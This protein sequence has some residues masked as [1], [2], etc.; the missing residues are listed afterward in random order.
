MSYR[1]Q[2]NILGHPQGLFLLFATEMWE[3][4]SYYGMRAI[5]V[6]YLTQAATAAAFGWSALN[7]AEIQANAL[8]ILGTYAM[9]VYI[10][11]VIGGW[12]ADNKLGQ[13]KAVIIGGTTMMLGQFALGT[14]HEYID[15]FESAFLWLGLAL[16]I[17]GNGFFKPNIS[18][19]VGDLY[20]EGDN[21]RDSAFIIFYM[22]INLGSIL[23]SIVV[24][25]VG[26]KINYQYGFIAAGIGMGIGVIMQLTLAERFLGNVGIT[27]AAQTKQANSPSD[28]GKALT[29]EEKDRIKV[30]LI[31]SIFSVIFWSGFEQAAGAFNLF[32]KNNTD[33]YLLGW[34][35]P[36]SWLQSINPIFIIILAPII[37]SYWLKMG[38]NDPNSPVKFALGLLFLG[39]GFACMVG[40]AV[41]IGEDQQVKASIWWLIW[42]YFFHT[43][44]ELCLSP[45]GL[46]MVT[47]I[48]PMRY[49]SLMMGTWLFFLG[50]GNKLASEAGKLVATE[51]PLNTF[52]AVT[53][54]AFSA[55]LMLYLIS[56]KLV[57]WMHGAD[58][59]ETQDANDA[60][61]DE[62][63]ITADHEGISKKR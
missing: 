50:I 45:V 31:L 12:F 21:R 26:E 16:L 62:M 60:L 40:A 25:T 55:S 63:T 6:L 59:K 34:E 22:G 35:M 5:F 47:K 39:L 33:L 27:P 8:S 13:R 54:L 17:I 38:N 46:S 7:P 57:D 37:A 20:K 36:A 61:I 48:A 30:F 51:G 56:D 43:V 58:N 24:G 4:M 52:L 9:L 49:L 18:T 29:K 1:S 3:R 10:T 41:Q 42:A 11:P 23:G 32:A 44:G 28:A 53:L 2:K 14:P 19:M 15:G